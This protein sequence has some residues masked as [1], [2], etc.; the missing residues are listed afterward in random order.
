MPL[1]E[2]HVG[3]GDLPVPATLAATHAARLHQL[4]KPLLGNV[5]GGRGGD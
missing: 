3:R 4:A 2:H 5:G 1:E